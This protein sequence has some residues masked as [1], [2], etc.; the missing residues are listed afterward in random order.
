MNTLGRWTLNAADRVIRYM[1]VERNLLISEFGVHPDGIAVIPNGVNTEIFRPDESKRDDACRRLLW[2]GRYVKGKGIEFLIARGDRA[3][4]RSP[5]FPPDPRR[6]G[7][8]EAD[9]GNSRRL[10]LDGHIEYLPFMSYDEMLAQDQRAEMLVLPS[11]H[12]GVP[13]PCSRRWPAAARS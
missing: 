7:A 6:R 9:I 4:P 13:E 5:R 11:L 1:L 3:R 10:R 8:E 12:E 2:V